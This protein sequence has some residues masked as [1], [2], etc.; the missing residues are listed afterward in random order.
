M[1]EA[2][3]LNS[4]LLEEGRILIYFAKGPYAS[5]HGQTLKGSSRFVWKPNVKVPFPSQVWT[6]TSR[7]ISEAMSD[8]VPILSEFL[9]SNDHR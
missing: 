3:I 2:L 8:S 9:L 7:W 4:L 6:T 5:Y 1:T